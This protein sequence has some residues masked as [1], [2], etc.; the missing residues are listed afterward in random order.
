MGLFYS[1]EDI[2]LCEICIKVSS[3]DLKELLA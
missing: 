2:A 3:L 1:V